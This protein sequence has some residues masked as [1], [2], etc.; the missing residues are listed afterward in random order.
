VSSHTPCTDTNGDEK[1]VQPLSIRVL[2]HNIRYAATNLDHGEQP[3]PVRAPQIVAE[4]RFHT[5][6]CP[7]AFICLQEVLHSQLI[8]IIK[9][10]NE[11]TPQTE[12]AEWRFLGVGRDDGREAGEYNPIIYRPAVWNLVDSK[13]LWL[14]QT[15]NRP[16]R[17]WDAACNRILTIGVFEHRS[18]KQQVTAMNT[19]LDHVGISARRNSAKFIAEEVSKASNSS[20]S[21]TSEI[22]IFLSGD[23]NSEPNQEAYSIL[24]SAGSPVQDLREL[25]VE[26]RRYGHKYTFTGFGD[27]QYDSVRID[28]LFIS[29]NGTWKPTTYAVLENIFDELYSSDHRAVVAD[30]LVTL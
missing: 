1:L 10:L 7:T 2:T 13:T 16:S 3:W 12:S 14:S 17:G 18:S 9:A 4:L 26:R 28:F 15:P 19:H 23:F 20:H 24:N 29:K 22:P 5:I 21:T 27:S 30:M 25:I 8:D 11:D 6:N